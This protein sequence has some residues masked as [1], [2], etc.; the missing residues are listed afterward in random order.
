MKTANTC[1]CKLS[2]IDNYLHVHVVA[3]WLIPTEA[4]KQ[5]EFNN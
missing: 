4:A 3:K 5:G 2:T 1:T